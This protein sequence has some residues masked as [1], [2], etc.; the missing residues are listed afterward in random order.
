MKRWNEELEW[1]AE[2]RS[3]S[4][5][6]KWG[7]AY[8]ALIVAATATISIT[9]F[10]K[11]KKA[12]APTADKIAGKGKG[13]EQK[14]EGKQKSMPVRSGAPSRWW[15]PGYEFYDMLWQW[16]ALFFLS[17]KAPVLPHAS[18]FA[19]LHLSPLIEDNINQTR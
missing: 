13:K 5:E 16:D 6:L 10:A 15:S 4:E 18:Q 2:V 9:P 11:E 14:P 19:Y 7:Q 12:N 3:W 17:L 8:R 1:G